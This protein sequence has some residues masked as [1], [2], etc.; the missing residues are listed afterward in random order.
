[1]LNQATDSHF[2]MSPDRM[3]LGGFSRL[4]STTIHWQ[5]HSHLGSAEGSTP[6]EILKLVSDRLSF[7]QSTAQAS[8]TQAKALFAISQ[9]LDF[10]RNESIELDPSIHSEITDETSKP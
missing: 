5:S 6:A 10:L 2:F 9:A 8:D 3:D 7:L 4:N 1:M